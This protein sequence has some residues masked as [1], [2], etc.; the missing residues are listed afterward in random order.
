MGTDRYILLFTVLL[1][2]ASAHTLV[3]CA[4]THRTQL[5]IK[6]GLAFFD[7]HASGLRREHVHAEKEVLGTSIALE[8]DVVVDDDVC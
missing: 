4:H 1:F 7:Q 3:S 2:F 8:L 6:F 5:L